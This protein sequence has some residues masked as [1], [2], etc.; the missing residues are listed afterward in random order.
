MKIIVA[1]CGKIGT[2]IISSLLNEGHDITIIDNDKSRVDE[3]VNI[4]DVIGVYGG[5]VDSDTLTEAN[6]GSADIFI[7]ATASD[8]SNMLSCFF[9][10]RMGAKH[11]IARI[12][13]TDYND[14]SLSFIKQTL[15]LSMSI[16]P[17]YLA[18]K[19]LF[20]ILQLPSAVKIETF[21]SRGIEMI[22]LKLK[23][24]SKL[25]GMRLSEI[26]DKYKA[27]FLVC[28]VQRGDSIHIPDGNF[29]LRAG[30]KI[31]V[32]A[33][34]S[35][36]Q[37]LLK[38]LEILQ[39]QAKDIMILGGSRMAYYLA[40]RLATIG[41]NVK[42]IEHDAERCAL[43]CDELPDSSIIL[44]DGAQQ[45]LLLEEGL[46]GMDA[47]V[48]LTG[49]DEENILMSVFAASMN[50]PK[51]ISKINRDELALLADKLGLDSIVTPS[52][53]IANVIL[54]YVRALENAPG[55]KVETLYK[56]MDGNAEALEF[57]V[58]ADF[59]GRDTPLKD[60]RLKM[61]TLI[62]G[63][64]RGRKIIIPTGADCICADDRVIVISCEKRLNDLSDILR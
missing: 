25:N 32:T 54:R 30:D 59:V 28:A 31:G 53:I 23:T 5:C 3:I 55:S 37:K 19:A 29:E 24:D 27:T 43:L 47:F 34:P 45:E 46:N 48:S 64:I 57:N 41:G 58:S 56:I 51:V 9:A 26:R 12:R 2:A 15:G 50:V 8:E 22:E 13:D 6:V 44:G 1:G 21:S 17:D 36:I 18:A 52:D 7:A 11:T 16:N 42:I 40:K 4:Y 10:K 61:N 35:E 49:M 38:K 63:I 20:N 14:R 60:L 33:S 62:A 39:K